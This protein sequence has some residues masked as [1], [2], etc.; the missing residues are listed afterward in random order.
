MLFNQEVNLLTPF[1]NHMSWDVGWSNIPH[2]L[3]RL[4]HRHQIGQGIMGGKCLQGVVGLECQKQLHTMHLTQEPRNFNTF[5][6]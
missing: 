1:R 3:K 2:Y 5:R 6:A 4:V